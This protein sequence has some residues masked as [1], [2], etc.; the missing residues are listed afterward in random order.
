MTERD[1]LLGRRVHDAYESIELSDEAQ[2]RMLANLLAAQQK[3]ADAGSPVAKDDAIQEPPTSDLEDVGVWR[4][5]E[6][7]QAPQG[8]VVRVRWIP[9]AI[10]ATVIGAVVAGGFAWS[11]LSSSSESAASVTYA[12]KNE[13]EMPELAEEDASS[14]KDGDVADDVAA[15]SEIDERA[16][17]NKF[18]SDEPEQGPVHQ[19]PLITLEDGTKYR[20]VQGGVAAGEVDAVDVGELV[21][22]AAATDDSGKGD[23]VSCKVYRVK[24]SKEVFAVRYDGEESCWYCETLD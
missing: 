21:G 16:E 11:V 4:E 18:Y 2:E 1:D 24:S 7:V 22:E 14:S 23:S 19:Y 5:P 8:K 6:P 13:A 17:H 3:R 9:M 12:G 20:L 15:A 10:A